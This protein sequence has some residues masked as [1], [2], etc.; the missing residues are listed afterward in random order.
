MVDQQWNLSARNTNLIVSLP[1]V[2]SIVGAIAAS[3]VQN[4]LGRKWTLINCYVLS[5]AG[6]FLQ[7]FA[8]N[9]AAFVIGRFWNMTVTGIA[10][11]TAPLYLSEVVPADYRGRAVALTNILTVTASLTAIVVVNATHSLQSVLSFRIPLAVQCAIPAALLPIMACLPESPQWL[12][13]K[14]RMQEAHINLR[15]LRG[16]SDAQVIDELRVMKKSEDNRRELTEGVTFLHLFDRRN[17]RRTLVAGACFSF[18]QLSG[19]ILSTTFAT[20][21]LKELKIASPFALSIISIGCD[22][23]GT[24]VGPFVV[25]KLGRR[26]TALIGLSILLIIDITAGALAFNLTRANRTAI[27]A[28]SFIFNFFWAAS[29]YSLSSVLP[30]EIATPRLRNLTMS[31]TIA[32]CQATAVVTTF[33]VPQLTFSDAAGLGAK[34]YL[35]FAGCVAVV[36][37]LTAFYLPETKG[38]TFAEIDEMYDEK[39]PAWKWRKYQTKPSAKLASVR[40]I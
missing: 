6:V 38:R 10:M 23:A 7:L 31:Y 5:L 26:P 3:P 21:F 35:V 12:A 27:A 2:G 22:L 1:L 36:I 32:W 37:V 18:N 28:L 14:D 16:F 8:P 9:L 20:V 30:S 19:I 17:R 4:H 24:V 39:V 29:F 33:V 40:D 34:T 13:S 11:A 15:K 25:D